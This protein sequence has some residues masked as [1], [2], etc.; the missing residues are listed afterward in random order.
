MHRVLRKRP[1]CWKIWR[2]GLLTKLEHILGLGQY[3]ENPIFA[4]KLWAQEAY[5]WNKL[6]F[7]L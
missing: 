6:F 4:L 7:G 1:K 5:Q 2:F 3:F